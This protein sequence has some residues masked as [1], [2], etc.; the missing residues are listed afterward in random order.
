[1]AIIDVPRTCWHA[2]CRGC[3]LRAP[4]SQTVQARCCR[5]LLARPTQL[6]LHPTGESFDSCNRPLD[7]V[8]ACPRGTWEVHTM[9]V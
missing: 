2:G 8:R 6:A 7:K 3:S 9:A 1:M 5:H 4:E